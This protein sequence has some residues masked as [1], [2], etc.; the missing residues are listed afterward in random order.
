MDERKNIFTCKITKFKSLNFY[1]CEHKV[2]YSCNDDQ[3]FLYT[4]E[5]T[6][7]ILKKCS[8]PYVANVKWSF[9]FMPEINKHN[10]FLQQQAPIIKNASNTYHRFWMSNK[11][12]TIN[13]CT[14][15]T[16][17]SFNIKVNNDYLL[18]YQFWKYHQYDITNFVSCIY[19]Q[20]KF[21]QYKFSSFLKIEMQTIPVLVSIIRFKYTCIFPS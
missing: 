6:S 14:R 7:E 21:N 4:K 2:Y 8:R 11:L 17:T 16:L 5:T 1:I 13:T 15:L 3:R 10:S 19:K 12:W 9:E 18:I 20:Y